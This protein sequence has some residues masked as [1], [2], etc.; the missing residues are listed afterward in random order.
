MSDSDDFASVNCDHVLTG[1]IAQ[2]LMAKSVTID[3][4]ELESRKQARLL[5]NAKLWAD[6]QRPSTEQFN[7]NEGRCGGDNDRMLVA[8]KVHKV[9][10]YGFIR[11]Y[12][13]K[14]TLILVDIDPSKKQDR[15]C[16]RI[17]KRAKSR[18]R[19]MDTLCGG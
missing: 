5:S 19:D 11:N 4:C 12:K 9:R 3:F 7:G 17:L 6:G 10:L 18:V 2:V 13:S 15:A 16:P 8:I 14:K 1:V